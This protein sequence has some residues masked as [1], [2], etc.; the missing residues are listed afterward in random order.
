MKKDKYLSDLM[1]FNCGIADFK[2]DNDLIDIDQFRFVYAKTGISTHNSIL[3]HKKNFYLADVTVK[4]RYILSNGIEIFNENDEVEIA[5]VKVKNSVIKLAKESFI[6]D[7]FH[8]DPNI[9]NEIASEIKGQ[10]IKKYFNGERGDNC[11][12]IL[13]N[14]TEAKGFLLTVIR[15]KEVVIDAIAVDKRFRKEGVAKKLI[16]GMINHYKQNYSKYSVWTQ[17]SYMPSI[18]LYQKFGFNVAEYGLVWHYFN[19]EN[20]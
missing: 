4:Y 20:E 10:W 12:V 13:A 11:F 1:K 7:R 18:N 3:A 15:Q 8:S 2:I 17:A 5:N 6:F 9:P 16:K 14:E 19:N